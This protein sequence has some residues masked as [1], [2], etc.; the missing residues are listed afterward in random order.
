MSA[1]IDFLS[2]HGAT[3][4]IGVTA[5]LG[6]GWVIVLVV[7]QPIHKQ[8]LAEITVIA[9]LLWFGLAVAPW[10]RSERAIIADRIAVVKKPP[11]RDPPLFPAMTVDPPPTLGNGPILEPAPP[12]EL[13][14]LPVSEPLNYSDSSIPAPATA[15][16]TIESVPIRVGPILARLYLVSAALALAALAIAWLRLRRLVRRAT[17]SSATVLETWIG[18]NPPK[19]ARLL[20][21]SATPLSFGV[22][23]PTVIV[24]SSLAEQGGAELA[25]VLRHELAHVRNRDALSRTVFN[26]AMPILALHPFYW[27]LRRQTMFAAELRADDSAA[28]P[29]GTGRY[30]ESLV[31]LFNHG[32]R[33]R[34][35]LTASTVWASESEFCRRMTML[36]KRDR[37]LSQRTSWTWKTSVA[38]VAATVVTL[39]ASQFGVVHAQSAKT[40][41]D[42]AAILSTTS[43]SEGFNP[44]SQEPS[45][46]IIPSQG[47]NPNDRTND[48]SPSTVTTTQPSLVAENAR[49]SLFDALQK[50]DVPKRWPAGANDG[51]DAWSALTLRIAD[52]KSKLAWSELS[53]QPP[54][55]RFPLEVEIIHL[56]SAKRIASYEQELRQVEGRLLQVASEAEEAGAELG[57]DHPTRKKLQRA[58]E[59]L[60]KR[61]EMIK[62]LIEEESARANAR[63][64]DRAAHHSQELKRLDTR[65]TKTAATKPV[66]PT[67]TDATFINKLQ[68]DQQALAANLQSALAENAKLRDQL[69]L[70][71]KIST[72]KSPNTAPTMD[73]NRS[74]LELSAPMIRHRIRMAEADLP[75]HERKLMY[76]DRERTRFEALRKKGVTSSD[77]V[78]KSELQ[79]HVAKAE[80]M[81]VQTEIDSLRTLLKELESEAAAKRNPGAAK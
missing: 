77:E 4:A 37:S 39:S 71:N 25:A 65:T 69:A 49:S 55:L 13:A 81:K 60:E 7:P 30:V 48:L 61:R 38:A 1:A 73:F 51:G 14:P 58:T 68:Y 22:R 67:S 40:T 34:R 31:A 59:G 17:T 54:N 45:K 43:A 36:L 28:E 78:E 44:F 19:R 8:R 33:P 41:S 64:Q 23:N 79:I 57:S 10:P 46:S 18:L 70:L 21:G 56:E 47:S 35:R 3:L 26:V 42:D 66:G 32:G 12:I 16:P 11:V 15:A 27:L 53:G 72:A 20:V 80:L 5:V 50:E 63:V 75:L 74:N 24:P 52:C 2:E 9:A 62:R 29:V 6:V 76:Y